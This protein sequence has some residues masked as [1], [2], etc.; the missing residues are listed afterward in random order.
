MKIYLA[1]L[2]LSAALLPM[3]GHASPGCVPEIGKAFGVT[4]DNICRIQ[5]LKLVPLPRTLTRSG[6]AHIACGPEDYD[7][8]FLVSPAPY[9]SVTPLKQDAPDAAKVAAE[10]NASVSLESAPCFCNPCHPESA[11]CSPQSAC[12]V[13]PQHSCH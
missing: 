1:A 4:G 10:S 6:T 7:V 2:L 12:L 3:S 13:K 8:A 5:S 11:N 9:C